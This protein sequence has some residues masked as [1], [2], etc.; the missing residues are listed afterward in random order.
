MCMMLTLVLL[1]RVM[2]CCFM[3]LI[4]M[5][6]KLVPPQITGDSQC[7]PYTQ[8]LTTTLMLAQLLLQQCWSR[9][10]PHP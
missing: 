4:Q 2:L 7:S 9:L 10:S 8:S 6:L 5:L 3:L 1:L